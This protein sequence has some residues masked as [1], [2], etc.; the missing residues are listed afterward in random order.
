[1]IRVLKSRASSEADFAMISLAVRAEVV[2]VSG[3]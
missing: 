1:M 2:G 3:L